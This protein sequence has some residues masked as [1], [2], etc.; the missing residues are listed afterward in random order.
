MCDL[1]VQNEGSI[2]LLHP[3]SDAGL[4]WINEHIDECATRWGHGPRAAVV[5]EHRYIG[6]IVAGAQADGLSVE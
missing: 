6:N 4:G 2:F 3:Q 5:V 1:Y